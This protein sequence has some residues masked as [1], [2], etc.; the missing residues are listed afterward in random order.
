M[1]AQN[2]WVTATEAAELAGCSRAFIC[3]ELMAH[4]DEGQNRTVGGRLDGWKMGRSWAVSRLTATSLR[5]T[6]STRARIH[7]A[8]RVRKKAAKKTAR[9][10]TR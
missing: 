1:A 2:D 5:S 10:K 4:Y 7:E 3:K 8:V 9:R 6:L